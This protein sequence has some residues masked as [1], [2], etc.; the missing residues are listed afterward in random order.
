MDLIQHLISDCFLL[1]PE[2]RAKLFMRVVR[3]ACAWAWMFALPLL[4]RAA[5]SPDFDTVIA[6]L[7]ASRC[8]DCHSG[9]E[10]KGGLNLGQQKLA[11]AGGESGWKS[12]V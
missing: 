4:A 12:V 1:S 6:P 10:P 2:P 3:V 7:I 11:L 9:A 8:L 5:E